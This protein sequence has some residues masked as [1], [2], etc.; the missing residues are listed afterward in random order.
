MTIFNS[1]TDLNTLQDA[2]LTAHKIPANTLDFDPAQISNNAIQV[3]SKLQAA[4]YQAYI[5]GGGIRDLILGL[6]PKDFDVATN[7]HPEQVKAVFAKHCRIIGR[8]FK[9]AHVRLNREIIEVATFRGE[10][11]LETDSDE[12]TDLDD[13][14]DHSTSE[15]GL[16]TSDNVY[17]T[18]EED[19]IR[20]DFTVNALYYDPQN[21]YVL[22]FFNGLADIAARRLKMI[23]PPKKR[24]QEDPVRTLRAARLSSKL[25]FTI[26]PILKHA[27][28]QQSQLLDHVPPARRFDEFLKLFLSGH[29]EKTLNTL[30]HHDLLIY[31]FPNCSQIEDHPH[32]LP[33][34]RQTAINTD[35]RIQADKHVTPA[36]LLAA[37]LWYSYQ[38][39]LDTLQSKA[40]GFNTNTL[41]YHDHLAH[42]PIN[43]QN[44]LHGKPDFRATQAEAF[45]QTISQQTMTLSIPKRFS[46][47]MREI[48]ELQ[49]RLPK[50]H[51][52]QVYSTLEHPRFR[53]AYD[54][55]LL[56][57]SIGEIPAGLGDWWTQFQM[58]ET[59]EQQ[60]MLAVVSKKTGNRKKR[61]AKSKKRPDS[62]GN[63]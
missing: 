12:T 57:E 11:S 21:A 37:I 50:R 54:F 10:N 1:T 17:G 3:V 19:A 36:F 5:V 28:G 38:A 8:R 9:L 60:K 31:L 58:A 29:A 26:D 16:V 18:L 53:A 4:G 48:W 35:E 32:L 15:E 43:A 61:P 46:F 6:T 45:Y 22:D 40:Q 51:P 7:A 20:R 59:E 33:M 62:F 23:G 27:I 39:K 41:G 14:P 63:K 34:L 25:D 13:Q 30:I 42:K 55:L 47:R 49:F 56:R 44:T 52:K 24:C 2:V